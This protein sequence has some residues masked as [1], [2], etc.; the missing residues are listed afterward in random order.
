MKTTSHL[1]IALFL[2]AGSFVACSSDGGS[3]D[4]NQQLGTGGSSAT[5]GSGGENS[6][7]GG[8]TAETG[9]STTDT[10]GSTGTGGS[11]TGD[12]GSAG[13]GDT[14][15]GGETGGS[16]DTGGSTGA[17]GSTG[18]G[19]STSGGAISVFD[20][21]SLDGWIQKP[22]NNWT[23]MDMAIY[24]QGNARGFIYTKDS[25]KDYRVIFT[26]RQ[27]SGN[28]K[29]TVL[30]YNASPDLDAMGG[31][32]FQPPQG[33][34]WDY[35]KGHNDAGAKYFTNVASG[36]GISTTEWA[37]CEILVL[38]SGTARMACC[39]LPGGTGT[40]KAIEILAFKDDPANLATTGPFAIQVH[41]SG[42]HDEYK[43]I[44]IEPNPA[45]MDLIT[46]K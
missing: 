44:T 39:Q 20:G 12:G 16:G 21:T 2:A 14:D 28:H 30:V 13:S 5:G 1:G 45:V 23:I 18:T 22:A 35:R 46:T 7:T 34:H 26:L 43:D 17:G 36:K 31:I 8:Q 40:C 4:G 10:G 9:G 24:G 3:G 37:R 38:S 25:Y 41:N 11:T 33:G 29:P 19:G 27:I 42:I 6:G 32:Q 15:A